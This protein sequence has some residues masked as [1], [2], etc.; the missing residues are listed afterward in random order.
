MNR[1]SVLGLPLASVMVGAFP[2][3]GHAMPD[4]SPYRLPAKG[5]AH[6]RTWMQWPA[7]TDIW[8]GEETLG[9]VQRTL[10]HLA[11]TIAT[12]EEVVMLVSPDHI[13]RAGR[14]CGPMVSLVPM[15]VDNMWA[16]DSGPIFVVS[17]WGELAVVD[18]NFNGWG[19]KQ[20]HAQDRLVARRV[21]AYCGVPVLDSGFVSDGGAMEADGDGT[22]ITT[23][24][25]LLNDNRNPDLGKPELEARLADAFGLRKVVWMP[26]LRGADVTDGHPDAFARFVRPG[27]VV[28]ELPADEGSV[29]F[30]AAKEA[31]A[32]LDHATDARGRKLEVVVLRGPAT[33][34][35]DVDEFAASY[36]GFHACNGGLVMPQ[37]GDRTADALARETLAR[38]HPGR[39]VVQFDADRICEGGGS[40]HCV[41]RQQPLVQRA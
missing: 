15:P 23:E 35:S 25:T 17:D 29:W 30:A 20:D 27:V 41:T 2:S 37:F 13:A 11:R 18:L 16:A 22:L 8:G 1:R 32:I 40:I 28:A 33:T 39:T 26:G 34:R 4:S 12:F 3:T 10:A 24:S 14:L 21:A 38:L 36:L 7:R 31:I 6:A 9:A 5:E 19:N